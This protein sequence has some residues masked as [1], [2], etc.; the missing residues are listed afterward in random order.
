MRSVDGLII[1]ANNL[2][3][4]GFHA[5][6]LEILATW[7]SFKMSIRRQQHVNSKTY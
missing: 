2:L 5:M 3:F 4:D 1:P 7:H 6:A